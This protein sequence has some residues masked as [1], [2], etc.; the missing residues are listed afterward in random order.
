MGSIRHAIEIEIFRGSGCDYHRP[1]DTFK[2]PE[3][4]G[5]LCPWLLDS[6]SSMVRVLQF[7]GTLPWKYVGT[8]FEKHLD[9]DGVT[10]EFVRCP[11]PTD[12]GVVVKIARRKL[13]APR[14]VGWA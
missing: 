8:E 12:A 14:D 4:V 13:E 2:Y 10:T 7:G 3:D 9:V 6:I 5:K 1:G 11:D